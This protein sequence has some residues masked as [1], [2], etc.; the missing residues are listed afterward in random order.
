MRERRTAH[1]VILILFHPKPTS[2]NPNYT[3]TTTNF[4]TFIRIIKCHHLKY[5]IISSSSNNACTRCKSL[6][7]LYLITYLRSEI[8]FISKD[9]YD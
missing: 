3:I 1:T 6:L 7:L 5:V 2:P 4:P 8:G 9:I